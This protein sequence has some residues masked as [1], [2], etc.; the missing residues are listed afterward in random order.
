MSNRN[1]DLLKNIISKCLK[2]A[3]QDILDGGPRG[4]QKRD[5]YIVQIRDNDKKVVARITGIDGNTVRG[6]VLEDTRLAGPYEKSLTGELNIQLQVY[7]FYKGSVYDIDGIEA[8]KR[9]DLYKPYILKHYQHKVV[10]SL[11]N[12]RIRF[13]GD[14]VATLRFIYRSIYDDEGNTSKQNEF[15]SDQVLASKY[16]G[17]VFGHPRFFSLRRKQEILLESLVAS[18]DLSKNSNGSYRL[19]G[20]SLWTISKFEIEERKHNQN[21]AVNSILAALT[22]VLATTAIIENWKLISNLF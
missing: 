9:Y 17:R 7:H 11:Y 6:R 15:Y 8:F 4:I 16:G 19:E 22:F 1:S 13:D 20:K 10:Q 21:L 5:N 3:A 14:R 12:R 18:G 2:K